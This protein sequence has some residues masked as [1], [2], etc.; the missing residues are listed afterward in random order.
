M[1]ALTSSLKFLSLGNA[2]WA[3][4]KAAIKTYPLHLLSTAT[5]LH[6][7]TDVFA[8]FLGT[9]CSTHCLQQ[10]FPNIEYLEKIYMMKHKN[11]EDQWWFRAA[12]QNVA[13]SKTSVRLK[14][15]RAYFGNWHNIGF[16]WRTGISCASAFL[17]LF[18]IDILI[19]YFV[20]FEVSPSL[21]CEQVEPLY[22][23]CSPRLP[24]FKHLETVA[25]NILARFTEVSQ[26]TSTKS[27]PSPQCLPLQDLATPVYLHLTIP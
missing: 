18:R 24:N 7:A 15:C 6:N 22:Q 13:W 2:L 14:T 12:C 23:V 10:T 26:C 20:F 25:R 1:L 11:H 8:M 16:R 9:S 17:K 27:R 4:R 21:L 19:E 3:P 5:L